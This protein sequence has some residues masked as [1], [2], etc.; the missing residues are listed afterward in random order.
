MTSP[1]TLAARLQLE[2]RQWVQG[3]TQ[4]QGGTKKFISGVRSEF[5]QLR[6]FLNSTTGML[7]QVGLGFGALNTVMSSAKTDQALTRVKQTADLTTS[8]VVQLRTELHGMAQDTGIA[9][10]GLRGGFDQLAAGGLTFGQALP[11]IEAINKN[12]RVTGSEATTLASALQ[13]AQTNFGFDLTQPGKA[14]ELLD[15]M[16]VAGRAGVIEIEDLAGVF[17]TAASNAKAAGLTFEQTL[18]LFEGLGTATTKERVG[19]LVD[20]TL[21]LFTNANYMKEAQKATGVKFFDAQG[22]RRNPLDIL[23]DIKADYDKLTTDRDRFAFVSKAF[24]KADLDTIKGINQAMAA[25]RIDQIREIAAAVQGASGTTMRDLPEAMSNSVAQAGVLRETLSTVGDQVSQPINKALADTI[26]ALTSEDGLGLN[27]WELLGGGALAAGGAYAGGRMAKGALG[28]ILSKFGG[29]TASLGAG[30]VAGTALQQAGAATP[31]YIVG[32]AP[33]LFAD[34]GGGNPLDVV[35]PGES[36][37]GKKAGRW[38]GLG[39]LAAIATAALPAAALA[40]GPMI[41]YGGTLSSGM[42]DETL[43]RDVSRTL[44][45]SRGKSLLRRANDQDRDNMPVTG[46]IAVEVDVKD[47]RTV[48]RITKMEGVQSARVTNPPANAQRSG[49]MMEPAR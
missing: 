2:S 15:K 14:L 5:A 12:M 25:G 23:T 40:A 10:D 8:Q 45:R 19:T 34:M 3:L 4:A 43:Q 16:T 47:G 22:D 27:G 48:G 31:V 32:A 39:S 36:K 20:S 42:E 38:A 28:Q 11:T 1:L 30:L 44:R 35:T 29:S 7:A 33:G 9:F 37:G 21:R 17:G 24:G 6:G 46:V 18:A 13:S 41:R 49:R 26:K